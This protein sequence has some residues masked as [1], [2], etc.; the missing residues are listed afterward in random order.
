MGNS[1]FLMPIWL[2]PAATFIAGLIIGLIIAKIRQ[3]TPAQTQQQLEDLQLRFDTYQNDVMSHFN[4]TAGLVNTLSQNYQAIQDHIASGAERLSLDETARQQ[5]LSK[6]QEDAPIKERLTA[7]VVDSTQPPKDYAPKG[8]DEIGALDESY[9]LKT[10][11]S[12]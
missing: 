6:L 5:L 11:T 12:N 4:T 9:G 2:L 10:K 3:A 7:P 8:A 1:E